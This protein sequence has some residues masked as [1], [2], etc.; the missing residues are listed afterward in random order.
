[1]LESDADIF[2]ALVSIYKYNPW[3]WLASAPM[4][5][6]GPRALF[7][8]HFIHLVYRGYRVILRV[9]DNTVDE[10]GAHFA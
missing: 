6:L 4:L 10:L 2:P 3:F 5:V 8:S 7:V 1:M 9:I